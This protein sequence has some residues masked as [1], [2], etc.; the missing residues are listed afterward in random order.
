MGNCPKCGA[1]L[2]PN[3]TL[4]EYCGSRVETARPSAGAV[5][6][7]AF[8]P[9][10]LVRL[11]RSSITGMLICWICTL[12]LYSSIWYLSRKGG[13]KALDLSQSR[14]TDGL[15][16][17]YAVLHCIFFYAF[18]IGKTEGPDSEFFSAVL[19]IFAGFS[20]YLACVVRA[21]LRGYASRMTQQNTA[22]A[23]VAPSLF[24]TS[25]LGIFYLQAH[26]NRMMDARLID[27]KL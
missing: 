2:S 26:I 19:L 1:E 16:K 6:P 24:W 4:C 12:G 25:L 17:A 10:G 15:I 9:A 21:L 13:L 5:E 23:F 11:K 8:P 20:I 7:N 22:D 18:F 27:A 3:A 14:K